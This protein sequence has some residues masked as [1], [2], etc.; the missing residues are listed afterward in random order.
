M[1]VYMGILISY[2]LGSLI[3]IFSG[4]GFAALFSFCFFLVN[5]IFIKKLRKRMVVYSISLLLGVFLLAGV[6]EPT[7]SVFDKYLDRYIEI[8]GV[9]SEVPQERGDH[10]SYVLATD[11][12]SYLG[13][14]KNISDKIRVNYE[15]ELY[16]GNKVK[17]RGYLS[18]IMPPD[19]STEFDYKRYYR[20]K[21][22]FYTQNAQEAQI[23]NMRSFLFSPRYWMEYIKGNLSII[24]DNHYKNDDAGVLKAVLLGVKSE[25]SDDF[26]NALV[27]TSAM[28]FL[29]PSFLH[30]FLFLAFVGLISRK[31]TFAWKTRL[32][33]TALIV[34]CLLNGNSITFIRAGIF[35]LVTLIYK[36][37]RG[38]SDFEMVFSITVFGC[39]VSNP[40]LF[41]NSGFVMSLTVGLLIHY[42][43]KPVYLKLKFIKN[44]K[45]RS[46]T[47]L[48]I[49][50]TVGLMPLG[51][52]FFGGMPLY[53]I[54]FTFTYLPL[55]L[56]VFLLSPITL[57]AYSVFGLDR[58][59]GVI[60][61]GAIDLMKAI[62]KI[63]S[64]LPW[65]YIVIPKT[66][67]IGFIV[68]I[69]FI[70]LLRELFYDDTDRFRIKLF[71][72]PLSV[73][74]LFST[75]S[76]ILDI[77]KMYVTFIN[78]GQGDGAMIEV[79][80]HDT[81]L[82]DGGGQTTDLDYNI[83]KEVYL[84]YLTAKGKDKIDLAIVSHFHSDHIDG[85][86]EAVKS[87]RVHTLMMPYTQL[88]IKAKEKLIETANNAGTNIIEASKG[89]RIEFDSGL[90]IEVMSPGNNPVSDEN[91]LSLV[92]KVSYGETEVLF[93]GD[94]TEAVEEDLIG[95]VGECDILKVPH[96]GSKYSSSKEFISEITP[97]F[98]VISAGRNNMYGHPAD[99]VLLELNNIGSEIL[100]TDYMCDI[101]LTCTKDGKIG[102][103]WYGEVLKWQQ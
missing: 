97:K 37:I 69:L 2:I 3:Y 91:D 11:S 99:R 75:F 10:C 41:Y 68:F 82:I 80:G 98:S 84:P 42:F 87:L 102:A 26:N 94:I 22:I 76:K 46:Y 25:F 65:H 18:E 28:R 43:R 32:L 83:G 64:Y 8:E 6:S 14:T 33:I 13:E 96:H 29:Y 39:L 72:I 63:V 27:K 45:L 40:L 53:S 95:K 55:S 90:L 81:I 60:L 51:A 1:T 12:L 21:G 70:C 56:I 73:I 57:L 61:N 59:F 16:V 38:F 17:F 4:F 86:V 15:K 71:A 101:T 77:G 85:I 62:P 88:D 19:N 24:I 74:I 48:W 44:K 66:T 30:L 100:R 35:A 58:S 20:S 103:G 89:D 78:V 9:I 92:L 5:L 36:K 47:A 79:K 31:L 34:F 93:T 54:I 50:T 23:V 7:A 67:I 52:Y 49:I